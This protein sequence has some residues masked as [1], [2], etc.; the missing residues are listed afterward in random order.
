MKRRRHH[1]GAHLIEL[2]EAALGG[3]LVDHRNKDLVSV[4]PRPKAV[5]QLSGDRVIGANRCDRV[6]DLVDDDGR[7]P[8]RSAALYRPRPLLVSDQPEPYPRR[9]RGAPTRQ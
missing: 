8:S 1:S 9:P 4:T 7:E 5:T 2:V 6:K 3:I